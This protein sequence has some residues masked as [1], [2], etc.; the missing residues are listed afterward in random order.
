MTDLEQDLALLL[1]EIRIFA[2][3]SEAE[4]A[5]IRSI[6]RIVFSRAGATL[7]R[8]DDEARGMSVIID[9][10]VRI[11]LDLPD[12]TWRPLADLKR[13]DV[14]GELS[15]LDRLPLSAT[16]TALADTR[17]FFVDGHEF[18]LM[19]AHFRPAAYKVVRAIG[20]IVCGRLCRMEEAMVARI[21]K[22]RATP[23]PESTADVVP[24][25]D[26]PTHPDG[27]AE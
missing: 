10:A 18:D 1:R 12:G 7:V 22:N 19:R 27:A 6:G 13:G 3:L 9:G 20:P 23:A 16:A 11:A 14:F 8:P 21:L 2:T 25:D 26:S 15:L 5:E 17:S 4:I 24:S